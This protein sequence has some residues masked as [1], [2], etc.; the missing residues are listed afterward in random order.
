MDVVIK[1]NDC[2]I[3]EP[4]KP[5]F[6]N[7][8]FVTEVKTRNDVMATYNYAVKHNIKKYSARNGNKVFTYNEASKTC[9][10]IS[11]PYSINPHYVD[12]AFR[13]KDDTT[14]DTDTS[15]KNSTKNSDVK[16]DL[17]NTD[18]GNSDSSDNKIDFKNRKTIANAIDTI[19]EGLEVIKKYFEK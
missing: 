8:V 14:V 5:K 18:T 2:F 16:H 11:E 13:T 17:T 10:V 12:Q 7:D 6:E 3:K 19:Q 1:N 9:P 15:V 4:F